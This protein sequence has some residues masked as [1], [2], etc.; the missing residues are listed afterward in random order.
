LTRESLIVKANSWSADLETALHSCSHSAGQQL[1]RTDTLKHWYSLKE[2]MRNQFRKD[3]SELLE[4]KDFPR[5]YIQEFDFAHKASN[6]ILK[7]QSFLIKLAETT[8]IC[9]IKFT[10]I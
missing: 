3:F 1:S 6:T 10:E 7:D 2:S 5:G 8:P 4:G 9:T